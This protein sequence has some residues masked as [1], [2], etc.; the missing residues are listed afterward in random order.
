MK[1]TMNKFDYPTAASHTYK[2]YKP[3]NEKQ[4]N[5]AE[6]REKFKE[7]V[8]RE[9]EI[10]RQRVKEEQSRRKKIEQQKHKQKI[11]NELENKKR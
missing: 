2:L 4:A 3:E 11:Q 1:K 7:I 10:E 6:Q 5:T 8:Q 9:K